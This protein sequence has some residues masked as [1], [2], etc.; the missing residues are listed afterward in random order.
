MLMKKGTMAAKESD[1]EAAYVAFK[2]A[3]AFDPTNELA[4]SEMERMVR[5][6]RDANDNATPKAQAFSVSREAN[7]CLQRDQPRF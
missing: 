1:F 3:Y 5:L 7:V 4:K 6:Q 2:R